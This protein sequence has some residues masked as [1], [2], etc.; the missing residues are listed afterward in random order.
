MLRV[1]IA[2]LLLSLSLLA[3]GCGK[4]ESVN[5]PNSDGLQGRG[6]LVQP[7]T[8]APGESESSGYL[9]LKI[10]KVYEN[11]KPLEQSPWHTDGGE[12]LF[13]DC[14]A[15]T[16]PNAPCV[17]GVKSRDHAR[18]DVSLIWGE[19]MLAVNNDQDGADFVAVFARAFHQPSPPSRKG[20]PP[21][22]IK[23]HTSVGGV[24][25]ARAP[26]GGFRG[27]GNWT[28]TKWFLQDEDTDAEVFFNYDP[29]GGKAEFAEKD[30][31]YRAEMI[32]YLATALRDGP[33]PER[34]PENDPNLTLDGP[35]VTDWKRI[36]APDASCKFSPDSRSLAV[37]EFED[38]GHSRI[39]LLNL[40]QPSERKLL[41]EFETISEAHGF[42]VGAQPTL[43][44]TESLPGKKGESSPAN[45]KQRLW[46]INAIG[47]QELTISPAI[48]NW[49]VNKQ[50]ISPDGRFI[51]V[52][53]WR[54]S[55]KPERTRVLHVCDISSGHW[56][57]VENPGTVLGL[58]SWRTDKP[59]ARS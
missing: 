22:F 40:T 39:Y 53:S 21:R 1:T 46:L 59:L 48:T 43:L 32:A 47:K 52:H 23:L 9:G 20:K 3:A 49:Y 26:E 30:E 14:V 18:P 7:G 27:H 19:A 24:N 6:I 17:I 58:A 5:K 15:G 44:V 38:N 28:A 37:S 34:T 33:L 13:M 4:N 57:T 36:A 35:R 25:L 10:L 16:T 41:A 2:P 50:C 45:Y 31:D 51:V 12:W 8:P 11:Q 56:R 55:S 54:E 29:K 42:V